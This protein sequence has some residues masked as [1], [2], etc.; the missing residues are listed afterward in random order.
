MKKYLPWLSLLV[1]SLW[2]PRLLLRLRFYLLFPAS[3][4]AEKINTRTGYAFKGEEFVI[5]LT[6]AGVVLLNLLAFTKGTYPLYQAARWPWLLGLAVFIHGLSL[7]Y[8]GLVLL[9]L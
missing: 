3:T 7:L 9:V 1:A 8:C 4:L 5:K 6:L 2:W